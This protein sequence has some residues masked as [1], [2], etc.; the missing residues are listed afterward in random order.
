MRSIY[1]AL[2]WQLPTIDFVDMHDLGDD[3]V[4]AGFEDPVMDME[5]LTLTWATPEA[6]ISELQT[7]G[8]NVARGRFEGLRTALWRDRLLGALRE[9][10][11]QADGRLALT[12]E[13]VY[14]HAIKPKPRAKVEAETRV[15]LQDMRRM[16][17]QSDRSA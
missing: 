9:R 13:L 5:R 17:R 10:L 8:G 4:K 3:L 7:W 1:A 16:I 11:A 6:L 15:S 12:V 2:G 14:G